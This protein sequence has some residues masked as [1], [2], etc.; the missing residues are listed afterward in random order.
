MFERRTSGVLE[1]DGLAGVALLMLLENVFPSISS[2]LIMPPA[3][4]DAA[5]GEGEGRLPSPS[6][7]T[8]RRG[9]SRR[10][11][12]N[13]SASVGGEGLVGTVSVG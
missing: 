6:I 1:A 11:N 10:A 8:G 7:G 5:R 2:E 9:V 3:G 4:F 12:R 13:R